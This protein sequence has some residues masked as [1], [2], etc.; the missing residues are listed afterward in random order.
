MTN[1]SMPRCARCEKKDCHQGKD[2]FDAADEHRT[3]YQD[4]EIARLQKAASSIEARHYCREPRLRE[5]IL[6]AEQL[7]CRRVGLA[8]CIG[9][10]AE[11]KIVEQI[12]SRHFDVASVCCKACGMPKSDFGLE[13]IDPDKNLEVTCNPAGQAD[14]LNRAGTDLNILCGLCVGHDA[15]F[16]KASNAPVT[17]FVA[18]D[19]VLAHNPLGAVYCRYVRRRM[20][21]DGGV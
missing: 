17:T 21:D 8:F 2:C 14:L 9:L 18:K 13:Q 16:S 10:S 11:A 6:F 19:R 4:A 20:T 7:K 12:L 3:L 15:I 1:K 5:I